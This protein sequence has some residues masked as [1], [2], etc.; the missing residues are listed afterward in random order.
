MNIVRIYEAIQTNKVPYRQRQRPLTP[1][2]L[3]PNTHHRRLPHIHDAKPALL[4]P[5][6][7]LLPLLRSDEF[8]D[9]LARLGLGPGEGREVHAEAVVRADVFVQREGVRG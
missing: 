2:Y 5:I 6:S 3:L 4:A 7:D 9:G 8:R 1:H